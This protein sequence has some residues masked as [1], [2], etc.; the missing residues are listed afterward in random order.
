MDVNELL[1]LLEA[2]IPF[3]ELYQYLSNKY[4]HIDANMLLKMVDVAYTE[5][6]EEMM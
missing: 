5:Y 1:E 4:T 3:R 2:G 6:K